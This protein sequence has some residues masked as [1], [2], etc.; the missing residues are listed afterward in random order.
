MKILII[1]NRT[2]ELVRQ[3]PE[4]A[5][6]ADGNQCTIL[7]GFVTSQAVELA[8]DHEQFDVV[9]I[10]GHGTLHVLELADGL[11]TTDWLVRRL[12][13]QCNLR[14]IFINSCDSIDIGAMI[15]TELHV[16][17]IANRAPVSDES[18][19]TFAREVYGALARGAT[20]NEA[21]DEARD[22]STTLYPTSVRP[23]LLDGRA[24]EAEVFQTEVLAKLAALAQMGKEN[25]ARIERQDEVIGT[26]FT[27]RNVLYAIGVGLFII[28][29]ID[30]VK[31][32]LT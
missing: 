15:H 31:H 28:Q 27:N 6:V 13:G 5:R 19:Y 29:V 32:W 30:L 4:L 8:L 9:H 10:A 12:R 2:P 20:I 23:L 1:A 17:V 25:R 14:L 16:G 21:Y 7:D 22:A 26:I 24:L 3:Y 18:A 11:I